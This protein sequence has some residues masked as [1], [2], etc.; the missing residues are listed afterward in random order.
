LKGKIKLFLNKAE[1]FVR[2]SID[3]ARLTLNAMKIPS[4]MIVNISEKIK[5]YSRF[6]NDPQGVNNIKNAFASTRLVLGGAIASVSSGVA[7]SIADSAVRGGL[8]AP[9]GEGALPGSR[10]VLFHPGAARRMKQGL[11]ER[12]QPGAEYPDQRWREAAF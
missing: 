9:V 6:K 4:R 7:L 3:I 1:S 8:S 11:V 5:G 2:K 12:R 10:R